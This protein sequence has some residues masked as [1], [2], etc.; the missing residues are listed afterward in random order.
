VYLRHE[1]ISTEHKIMNQIKYLL[2]ENQMPTAWYNIQADLP[3]ANHLAIGISL[4][5]L[6]TIQ[7]FDRFIP[8]FPGALLAVVVAIVASWQFNFASRGVTVV[9]AVPSGLPSLG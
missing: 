5:V 7:L 6:I 2:T 1:A 3:H 4:A 9:G 8:K